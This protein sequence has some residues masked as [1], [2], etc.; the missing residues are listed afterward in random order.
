MLD[1]LSPITKTSRYVQQKHLEVGQHYSDA[2]N[3]IRSDNE[4]KHYQSIS[5]AKQLNTECYPE[6]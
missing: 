1:I 5:V 3:V 4:T 2:V 6:Q